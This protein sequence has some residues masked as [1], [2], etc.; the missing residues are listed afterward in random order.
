MHFTLI[1]TNK[2]CFKYEKI[3]NAGEKFVSSC[4]VLFLSVKPNDEEDLFFISISD[5][6]AYW[7]AKIV[8][9]PGIK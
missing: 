1:K 3:I 2:Q 6:M 4:R 9:I 8:I 5:C 7:Q